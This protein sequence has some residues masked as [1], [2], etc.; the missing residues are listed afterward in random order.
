[1]AP[2]LAQQRGPLIV[3]GG[4]IG[5]GRGSNISISRVR[6]R[7]AALL[8]VLCGGGVEAGRMGKGVVA[9]KCLAPGVELVVVETLGNQ[10]EIGDAEVDCQGDHGWDETGP[11]RAWVVSACVER[12]IGMSGNSG[13][14]E[15]EVEEGSGDASKLANRLLKPSQARTECRNTIH[16]PASR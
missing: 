14:E 3:V 13:S 6:I 16:L 8:V 11:E 15:K 2:L 4:S 1:M 9:G 12:H 7:I 10:D 5:V